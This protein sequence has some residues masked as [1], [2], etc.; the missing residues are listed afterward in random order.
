MI[1]V[2]LT[3]Y[4]LDLVFD[5]LHIGIVTLL[6]ASGLLLGLWLTFR[7]RRSH[8]AKLWFALEAMAGVSIF[9]AQLGFENDM[10]PSEL[11]FHFSLL[12]LIIHS[13]RGLPS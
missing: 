2:P 7:F 13:V 6:F 3:P 12:G 10:I 4:R 11:T 8:Y 5:W 9:A 1:L